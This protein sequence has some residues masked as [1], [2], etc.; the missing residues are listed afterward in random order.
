MKKK[1]DLDDLRFIEEVK[2]TWITIIK[3]MSVSDSYIKGC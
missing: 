2:G 3:D 1:K